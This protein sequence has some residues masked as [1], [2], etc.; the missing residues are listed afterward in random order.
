MQSLRLICALVL[1]SI[2]L[3][4]S[5]LHVYWALGGKWGSA[6]TIPTVDGLPAFHPGPAATCLVAFL[7]AAGALIIC[8]KARLFE[9]GSFAWL[10]PPGS[11]CLCAVFVLRTVGNLKTFGFFKTIQGTPFAY[12]D[13]HLY[14]P[15]CLILAILAGVVAA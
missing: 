2:L 11:W 15:L 13:T 8:G 1:A 3:F 12:W 5:S 7:L 9:T 4:L 6:A 14:S 10:F